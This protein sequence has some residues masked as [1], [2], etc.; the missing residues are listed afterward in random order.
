MPGRVVQYRALATPPLVG[1]VQAIAAAVA[2]Q[3][4]L[5]NAAL[6]PALLG[7][8]QSRYTAQALRTILEAFGYGFG[9]GSDNE[10]INH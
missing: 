8:L 6:H 3:P 7:H 5:F 9:C 2:A 4:A 1:E 10:T